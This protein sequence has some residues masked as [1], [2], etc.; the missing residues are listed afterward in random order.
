LALSYWGCLAALIAK[1][2]R[3]IKERDE[4]EQALAERES[5]LALAAKAG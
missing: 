5:H 4:A 1:T 2:G 3:G